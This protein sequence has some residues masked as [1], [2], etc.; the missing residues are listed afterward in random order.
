L[1]GITAT[2]DKYLFLNIKK[3]NDNIIELHDRLYSGILREFMSRRNHYAP[4]LSV[5]RYRDEAGL[6][7]ALDDTESFEACFDAVVTNV[8]SEIIGDNGDSASEL[9]VSLS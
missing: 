9:I 7:A 1:K 5:G 8:V 2:P 3:G 4:H 6:Q